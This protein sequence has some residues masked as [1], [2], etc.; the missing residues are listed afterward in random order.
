MADS[1]QTSGEPCSTCEANVFCFYRHP[2]QPEVTDHQAD[3][4]FAKQ[5]M[6]PKEGTLIPQHSH[7]YDH[8]TIVACGGVIVS[9]G[10]DTRTFAAP[11]VIRIRAGVKHSFVTTVDDTA[12]Y[13]IHNTARTG[14][15]EIAEE[16]ILDLQG[17]A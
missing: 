2:H 17:S 14:H 8:M 9:D 16:H 3:G 13:C 11:A 5:I 12:L 10:E 15:I 1:Q 4:V 7:C 6:I